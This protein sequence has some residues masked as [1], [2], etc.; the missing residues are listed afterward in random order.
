MP[1]KTLTIPVATYVDAE[2]R[3]IA[4]L[5]GVSLDALCTY[6]FALEVVHT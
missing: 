6:F 3:R 2:C 5:L 4:D 1:Y